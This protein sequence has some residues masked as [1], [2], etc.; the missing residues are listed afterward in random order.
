[1]PRRRSPIQTLQPPSFVAVNP[2]TNKIY[3][4][5][6]GYNGASETITVI[7]G[8]TNATTTLTDTKAGGPL[9]VA[10]N[11]VTNKIY[12]TDFVGDNSVMV[13]DGA[14]NT[15]SHV[16]VGIPR[17]T[18]EPFA[19]AVNPVTNKIYVA[20]AGINDVTVITEQQIEPIPLLASVTSLTGN[21]T[22]S[23]SPSFNFMASSNFS[24]FATIP[25][26]LLFQLD[27]RQ[28]PWTAAASQGG[29]AFTGQTSP[30]QL[31]FHIL[32]AFATDSQD[33]TSTNTGR[34]SSPLIGNIAAYG[35]LVIPTTA[36]ED[37]SLS[38]ESSSLTVQPAGQVTDVVTVAPINVLFEN[39]VQ[40]S[41][42]VTGPAPLPS[43]TLSPPSV[44]P[45]TN[46]ATSTLTISAP[47]TAARL[48]R[49]SR[50]Q[51]KALAA[52]WL[53]LMFGVTLIGGVKKLRRP[54]WVLGGLLLLALLQAACGGNSG[55]GGTPRNYTVTVTGTSGAIQHTAQVA[56]TVQ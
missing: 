20:N 46:S 12:I 14:T 27:T 23:L 2:V 9:G 40:L 16:P 45:G 15:T 6:Q 36:V 7:D 51:L 26:N 24:P 4:T 34:Q 53:P 28:A 49:A 39:A 50:R 44:T 37:F 54:Y 1:M 5:N 47:T 42:S 31:G 19:I 35:F 33:A 18:S 10:V 43:C 21:V 48:A 30:L 52:L 56:V 29:D 17:T 3:V 8:A 22:T 25:D 55:G 32:Y 11:P 41:C 13:I 38:A